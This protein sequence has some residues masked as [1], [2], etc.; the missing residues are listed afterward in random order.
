MA[1]SSGPSLPPPRLT[2]LNPGPVMTDERVRA[3]L[4]YPDV[5]HREDE[6]AA[7][8][9]AVRAKVTRLCEG[10][11]RHTS[12]LLT[13]SGTAALEAAF[14]SIVP[15]EGK[16]L[17][18]DNGNYGQR[19]QRIVDVHGVRHE[20]LE[21]G[22][23]VPFDLARIDEVLAGNPGFTHVGMVHHETSTGMLNPLREVGEI[24]ERHGCELAVDAI[25]SLGA[26]EFGLESHGVDWCV[27]TANKCLEGFPGMSFVCASH[28][29][30]ERLADRSPATLYLDLYGHY[31]AQD[32]ANAPLFTPAVQILYAFDRALDLA[33]AEGTAGRAKRYGR[34]AEALRTGL[35]ERGLRFLLPEEHMCRAVTNVHVPDGFTYTSLHDALKAEGFV[36]YACQDRLP[37]VFRVATMG[38]LDETDIDEFLSALDRVLG[39]GAR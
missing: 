25:S 26:E 28:A 36:I 37:D 22:W 24:A 39:E 14:A 30:F 1:D 4:S 38:R 18:L 29:A 23:T 16:I 21:F 35:R 2:L 9:N 20:R 19:L 15:P 10:T 6:A 31:A 11:E 7:L 33:L 3:A 32:K 34:L 5:C 8:M 17:I 27:G 12:V 13:G